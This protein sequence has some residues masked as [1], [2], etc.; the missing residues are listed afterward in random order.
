MEDSRDDAKDELRTAI[1]SKTKKDFVEIAERLEGCL[2]D[3]TG[4]QTGHGRPGLYSLNWTAAKLRLRHQDGVKG[5]ST[6]GHVSHVF[7]QQDEFQTDGL[8]H[9]GCD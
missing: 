2:K 5:S 6:E 4:L 3:E 9:K 7:G 1:R 8:E